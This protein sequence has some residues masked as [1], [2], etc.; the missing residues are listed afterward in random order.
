MKR[1][2]NIDKQS[3]FTSFDCSVYKHTVGYEQFL[4]SFG[5]NFHFHIDTT[6][7]HLQYR[8]LTGPEK[9]KLFENIDLD[10]LVPNNSKLL[11]KNQVWSDFYTVYKRVKEDSIDANKLE[12]IK[13]DLKSWCGL[14][15]KTFQ[16]REVTLYPCICLPHTRM[17]DIV[18]NINYF[19]QQGLEKLNDVNAKPYFKGTNMKG[20][21]T[22][23]QL[24]HK[25][26][27]TTLQ[28]EGHVR[29]KRAIKCG[30][31]NEPDH[32]KRTCMSPCT[33]CKEQIYCQHLKKIK[34]TINHMGTYML[35]IYI[36]FVV[37]ILR[38][39]TYHK[40]NSF[41]QLGTYHNLLSIQGRRSGVFTIKQVTSP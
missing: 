13:I 11:M 32:N 6:S 15:L 31:C 19:N 22:L 37:M 28:N 40:V 25:R 9:V 27:I 39:F 24:L 8:D 1:R 17:F 7:K 30:N 3:K 26:C 16:T 35:R 23:R 5:I 14:F 29:E 34:L 41:W 10:H 2:C 12:L 20:L 38:Y 33:K 4:A 18:C 21:D 36:I